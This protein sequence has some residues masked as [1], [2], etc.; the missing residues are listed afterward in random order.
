M[1]F[2]DQ[3][4]RIFEILKR[5]FWAVLLKLLWTLQIK[6]NASKFLIP[7]F[8][9]FQILYTFLELEPPS[10]SYSHWC[11]VDLLDYDHPCSLFKNPLLALCHL[12]R[13][14]QTL[15]GSCSCN[16]SLIFLSIIPL[17]FWLYKHKSLPHTIWKYQKYNYLNKKQP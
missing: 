17:F 8:S 7:Q 3:N 16:L 9:Q 12:W 14:V 11:Q 10:T 15:A 6:Y 4:Q 5:T 13:K 2:W 1:K